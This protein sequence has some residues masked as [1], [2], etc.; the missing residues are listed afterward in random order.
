M[1]RHAVAD[2]R[3]RAVEAVFLGKML[4]DDM[5]IDVGW[6]RPQQV[7]AA[8]VGEGEDG[9]GALHSAASEVG[10]SLLSALTPK[11]SASSG[12]VSASRHPGGIQN[13]A[14]GAAPLSQTSQM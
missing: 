5:E 3:R 1:L 12:F 2:A 10:V 8:A 4:G 11:R 7:D 9:I 14:C 6:Q 13:G